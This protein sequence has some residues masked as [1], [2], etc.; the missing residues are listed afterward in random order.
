MIHPYQ[1]NDC[2]GT[3]LPLATPNGKLKIKSIFEQHQLQQIFL[4]NLSL[5]C[6]IENMQ[7]SIAPYTNWKPVEARNG[8]LYFPDTQSILHNLPN[9]QN[10]PPNIQSVAPQQVRWQTPNPKHIQS[11][12]SVPAWRQRQ[13]PWYLERQPS[14]NPSHRPAVIPE[15]NVDPNSPRQVETEI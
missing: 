1:P 15:R 6:N 8:F 7:Y 13:T 12:P 14:P 5:N 11:T 4:Y 10:P 3:M 2:P 9:L